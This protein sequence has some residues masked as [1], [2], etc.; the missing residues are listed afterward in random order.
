MSPWFTSLLLGCCCL[1]VVAQDGRPLPFDAASW[2][3]ARAKVVEHLGRQALMGTAT[4][5]EAA[6]QDGVI[7]VDMAVTGARSYP[8]V[9][10][11][12]TS[13]GN[14]ERVYL[15]PH[16]ATLA[17]YPDVV[18]YLPMFNGVDSWQLYSGDGFTAFSD[19]PV[20]QWFHLKL[21]VKGAQARVYLGDMQRPALEIPR[22]VR[23]PATGGIGLMGPADG[24]AFFSNLSWRRS[25]DLVFAPPPP[26]WAAPGAVRA[27]EI[28][29]PVKSAEVDGEVYPPSQNPAPAGWRKVLAE[30]DGK[31]DISRTFGRT[32]G[33]PDTLFARTVLRAGQ[34]ELRQLRFGY[35]DAIT[36]FLNGKP[37]FTGD[38]SYMGRDPSFLGIVGLHDTLFLPLHKGENELFLTLS[39]GMGGWGFQFQDAKAVFEAPG[40]KHLWK[41]SGL[42]TPESAAYDQQREVLYVS[43]YDPQ[44]PSGSEGGQSISRVD[45]DGKVKDLVWVRG[46]RNPTGLKV[47]GDTLWVVE[48]RSVVEIHIPTAAIKVRHEV[49]EA[50]MLNDI[51]VSPEGTVY[52]SDSQRG[53]VFRLSEGKREAV[54][55]GPGF[56]RPNGL[57]VLGATLWVVTNGDASLKAV[58]LQSRKVVRTIPFGKG[59]GDGLV[60]DE[61]GNLLLTHH[62]GRLLRI[63]P[64][65]AITCLIDTTA[66]GQSLAD[67]TYVPGRRMVV[68][69]TFLDQGLV[70]YAI[71]K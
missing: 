9:L 56:S 55:E 1:S 38:S 23:D 58:D 7:E 57:L 51:E 43:N 67:L 54:V 40:V 66:T 22:L 62:E 45:L 29:A 10:F 48:P 42:R 31:L 68:I 52:V 64:E 15:R 53:V 6:F 5:K 71:P 11:R 20:G 19:V 35:S 28:S 65:G 4:L 70:A 49:P 39:E 14:A 34:A 44:H 16:R 37:V 46:L 69:P 21:E 61:A 59:L 41:T 30:S 12:M 18:Q 26:V 24:T 32:R 63:S 2:D 3:L 47:A 50:K 8:G 25:G 60:A 33:G 27:W 17:R 13:P 36:V